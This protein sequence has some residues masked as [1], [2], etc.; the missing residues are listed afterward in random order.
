MRP[1][2]RR[3]FVSLAILSASFSRR[4]RSLS[5]LFSWFSSPLLCFS[6]F[7]D[8]F[9]VLLVAVFSM[10]TAESRRVVPKVATTTACERTNARRLAVGGRFLLQSLLVVQDHACTV[11]GVDNRS[12]VPTKARINV[13][14]NDYVIPLPKKSSDFKDYWDSQYS[15]VRIMRPE[16]WLFHDVV[17]RFLIAW[18]ANL[19]SPWMTTRGKCEHQVFHG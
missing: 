1:A 4:L 18:Q 19:I 14:V 3:C 6:L 15:T 11:N 2:A 12:T 5:S 13:M 10:A 7:V 9:P 17:D 8:W 16:S